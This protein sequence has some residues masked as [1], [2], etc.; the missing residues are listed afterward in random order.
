MPLF[1]RFHDLGE[2]A[3]HVFG[4]DEEDRSAMR[5]GDG[6][7][8]DT[9]ALPLKPRACFFDIL[10]FKAHMVLSAE[11][12]LGEEG[13]YRGFAGVEFFDQLNLGAVHAAIGGRID[14]DDLKAAVFEDD[15]IRDRR[16]AHCVAVMRDAF[17]DG[18][19]CNPYVV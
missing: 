18:R 4:V 19:G 3:L 6:G 13:G 15:F 12:V 11:R 10:N 9:L 2:H 5:A 8:K 1:G 17:S 16:C 7:A 14:K